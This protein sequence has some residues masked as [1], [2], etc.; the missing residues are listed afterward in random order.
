MSDPGD[1]DPPAASDPP[2]ADAAPPAERRSIGSFGALYQA[3]IAWGRLTA[4]GIEARIVAVNRRGPWRVV[5]PAEQEARS[6]ALLREDHSAL[7]D[8]LFGADPAAVLP[9]GVCP[10]CGAP[11][12]TD[13]RKEPGMLFQLTGRPFWAN[14]WRCPQCKLRWR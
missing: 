6:Q 8:E 14:R 13:L 11:D 1:L 5:V 12:A 2:A 10:R 3:E 7:V 4:E 9:E